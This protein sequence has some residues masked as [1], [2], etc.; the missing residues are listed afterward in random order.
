MS[1]LS[2]LSPQLWWI[3]LVAVGAL[4]ALIGVQTVRLS[5]SE[6]ETAEVQA[7]WIADR[8]RTARAAV[9]AATANAAEN[10]RILKSQQEADDAHH[11]AMAAAQ[12]DAASAVD[13]AGRLR[14]RVAT[15]LASSR[16]AASDPASTAV[17]A[18]ANAAA[19]VLAQ[20]LSRMEKTAGELAAYGD[21]ARLAGLD[22]QGRYDALIGQ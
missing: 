21:S 18:P 5:N 1:L 17:F 19:D 6:R 22:C 11:Q 16:P 7:K 9:E 15:V 3:E 13:A 14:Q 4:V 10:A 8:E 20:L 2:R 12:A